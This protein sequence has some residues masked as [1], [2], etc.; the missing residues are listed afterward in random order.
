MRVKGSTLV[1]TERSCSFYK[2]KQKTKQQ[3]KK[4]SAV[5]WRG[6]ITS[7]AVTDRARPSL[8]EWGSL[9]LLAEL[10]S[11]LKRT[12][13]RLFVL[14]SCRGTWWE[15]VWCAAARLHSFYKCRNLTV[16]KLKMA[17]PALS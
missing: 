12:K 8:K 5:N 14:K 11:G 10:Y 17:V 9:S 13:R 6:M 3:Q 16:P 7:R 4:A 2:R 15:L 1:P